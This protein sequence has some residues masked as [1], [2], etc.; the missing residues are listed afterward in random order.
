M[1]EKTL[2]FSDY[3]VCVRIGYNIQYVD[4]DLLAVI[5]D[6]FLFEELCDIVAQSPTNTV[7]YTGFRNKTKFIITIIPKEI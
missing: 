1:N 7:V 5:C 2:N 4:M 3:S 6:K